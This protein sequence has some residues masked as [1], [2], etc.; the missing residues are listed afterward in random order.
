MTLHQQCAASSAGSITGKLVKEA[1]RK[2]PQENLE[3][4]RLGE[5]VLSHTLHFKY[6]GEMQYRDEDPVVLGE[7]RIIAWSRIPPY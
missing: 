4:M 7:Q 3:H 2:L 6:L 1:K 5:E